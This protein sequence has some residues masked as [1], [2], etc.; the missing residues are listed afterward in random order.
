MRFRTQQANLRHGCIHALENVFVCVNA[1]MDEPGGR[2]T[3]RRA[4]T[5]L[6]QR[7]DGVKVAVIDAACHYVAFSFEQFPDRLRHG[8]PVDHRLVDA[9]ANLVKRSAQGLKS[10]SCQASPLCKNAN[11]TRQYLDKEI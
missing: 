8:H 1:S 11:C 6:N 7:I 2:V 9:Q 5:R 3:A 4:D 10:A